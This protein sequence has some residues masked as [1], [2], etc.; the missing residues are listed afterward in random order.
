MAG[1]WSPYRFRIPRNILEF[2]KIAHKRVSPVT[3][4][5]LFSPGWGCLDLR[6]FSLTLPGPCFKILLRLEGC[7]SGQR[8]QTVNLPAH[9]YE[10]SN[11]SPSTICG[12][13]SA[14][15]AQP[16]QGWGRGF[17]SRLPL[18]LKLWMRPDTGVFFLRKRKMSSKGQ[19]Y[20]T[21]RD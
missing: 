8:E 2:L 20:Y 19:Y 17:E 10:G 9:A 21:R 13:S 4:L 7:P 11:P 16:C 15:R 14:G 6:I 3:G 18:Q 5:T 1:L 12:S